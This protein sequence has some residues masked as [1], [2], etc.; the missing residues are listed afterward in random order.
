MNEPTGASRRRYQPNGPCRDGP[1]A[2]STC[3][4]RTS[5]RAVVTLIAAAVL[6]DRGDRC[7]FIE[8]RAATNRGIGESNRELAHMHLAAVPLQQSAVKTVRLDFAANPL[9]SD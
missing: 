3:F 1:V 6:R 7:V 4:A 8:L 9:T 5:P 2:I